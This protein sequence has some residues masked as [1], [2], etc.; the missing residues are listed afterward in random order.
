MYGFI[1]ES[2]APGVATNDNDFLVVSLILFADKEAVDKS[3]TAIDRLRKRLK[4]KDNYEFHRSHNIASSQ[5]G[6]I[7]LIASLDFRFISIS[8]KKNHLRNH[9]SYPKMA[10]LLAREIADRFT[11]IHIEMDSNPVFFAEL[12]KALKA[13]KIKQIK[14]RQVKS[15]T[16]N[17]IQLADYV[18]NLSAKRVKNTQK[19]ADWYRSIAKKRLLF[20]DIDED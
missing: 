16:N 9:A 3:S 20:L 6:F 10:D 7:K 4:L 13:R 8:I 18:V 19:S 15:H 14:M 17:L 2:G 12:K 1:D 11:E 5:D